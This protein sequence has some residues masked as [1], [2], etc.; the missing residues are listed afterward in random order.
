MKERK[1]P[2]R[3][4]IREKDDFRTSLHG[5]T[6]FFRLSHATTSR[7]RGA[8]FYPDALDRPILASCP[9]RQTVP[10]R[11]PPPF[12]FV[13]RVVSVFAVSGHLRSQLR[14]NCKAR[15]AFIMTVTPSMQL[16][17]YFRSKLIHAT[18]IIVIMGPG[19]VVLGFFCR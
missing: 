8:R 1:P 18:R 17:P 4:D 13:P 16:T 7:G 15:A 3:P 9:L 6:F 11:L 2:L 12:G 10:S 14:H 5:K 19:C